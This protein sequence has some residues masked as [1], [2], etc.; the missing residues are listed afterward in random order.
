[1]RSDEDIADRLEHEHA[2]EIAARQSE[3]SAAIASGAAPP[4]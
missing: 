3:V 4:E 2:A 1:M